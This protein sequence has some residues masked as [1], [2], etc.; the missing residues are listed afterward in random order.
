M[1]VQITEGG[2]HCGPFWNLASI[3]E[4][5]IDLTKTILASAESGTELRD[6]QDTVAAL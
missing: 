6:E 3:P 4:L 5:F 1:R 2:D